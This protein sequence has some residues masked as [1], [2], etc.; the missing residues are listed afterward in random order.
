MSVSTAAPQ[1]RAP[2]IQQSDSGHK[3]ALRAKHAHAGVAMAVAT[4]AMAAASGIQAVLYL[5]SFGVGAR[6][7]G[8]FVAFALYATFGVFS[9]SIRVTSAPLLLGDRPRMTPRE[10]AATFVLISLPVALLTIP[11]AGP[12]AHLLAPGI[13]S[14]G[15]AVTQE[16]LPVLGAAMVLQLWAAG[17]ATLL[18][19]RDR[20]DRVAFA[21][22]VG[23]A[24]GLVVYLAVSGPAGELSLGWSMLAMAVVTC[25]LMLAGVRESRVAEPV[26]ERP[27]SVGYV[28]GCVGVVLGRTAVYLVFNALYLV[29]VAFASGHDAGDATVLSYAYLFASYLVAGTGFALGMSRIADMHRGVQTDWREVIRDTV[30]PG[31]RYAMMLVA[32]ALAALVAGGAPLIGKLFPS[33]FHAHEV[34]QLQVF[35]ALLAAWTIGALLVNL[36]LPAMFALD[37]ARLVN[38]LALP[39]MALH[40]AATAIGGALFGANGVVGA[41][42]VAPICFAVVLLVVGAGHASG[43]LAREL[44]RDGAR[45][46]L[47]AA[48]AFGIGAAVGSLSSGLAAGAIAVA[49]GS[50]LYLLMATRLAPQQFQLLVGAVRPAS[51]SASASA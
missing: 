13:E 32:P 12:F 27:L 18:A 7:D 17:G 20:F 42:F 47:A 38:I 46:S 22:I 2:D 24:A 40:I 37:R 19:I 48:A 3:D 44:A 9:Q 51:A 31:F 16:A 8:F 43:A 6:T 45:F 26:V 10:L 5:S 1:M 39:L 50:I 21:Y 29:T 49:V 35:G 36:L 14:S 30:P 41:A 11:L 34:R 28:I 4:F 23:A 33:S 25:A 15:R